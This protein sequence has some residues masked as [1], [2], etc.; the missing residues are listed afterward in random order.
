MKISPTNPLHSSREWLYYSHEAEKP[1]S[2]NEEKKMRKLLDL[3]GD[4]MLMLCAIA[5]ISVMELV[6]VYLAVELSR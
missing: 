6:F 5:G 3:L 1:A 4:V 2:S